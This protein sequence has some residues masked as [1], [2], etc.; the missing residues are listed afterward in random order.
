MSLAIALLIL[1][2]VFA[3]LLI[4]FAERENGTLSSRR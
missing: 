2:F 1:E 3:G 4:Y